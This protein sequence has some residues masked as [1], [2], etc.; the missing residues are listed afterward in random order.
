MYK[1]LPNIFL[2]VLLS[3]VLSGCSYHAGYPITKA[4]IR[5][6]YVAPAVSEAI[7]AQ[8]SGVL[9][10]QVRE[11][12]LCLGLA[13]LDSEKESDATLETTI[14]NYGRSIGS[15]DEYD[16]DTAKTLSLSATIKCSL[17]NNISGAYFFKD[18]TL[19]ASLSIAATDAAQAI[20]Y[21]RLPQLSHKLA[22]QVVMLIA[23]FDKTT[24]LSTEV[25][26][27]EKH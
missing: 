20:E 5:S 25:N 27:N 12:I 3:L 21:Q 18:K 13:A 17:K 26:A 9:S 10:S 22:R 8:M 14:V 4:G 1:P 16:P 23:M 2:G 7:V 11:E 6:I 15:V 24:E 19:S